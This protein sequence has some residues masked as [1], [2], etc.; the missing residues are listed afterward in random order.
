ML[1]MM[2]GYSFNRVE[3][4]DPNCPH[5]YY[6]ECKQCGGNDKDRKKGVRRQLALVKHAPD[7]TLVRHLP[8][9][10]AMANRDVT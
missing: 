4:L 5:R 7:C 9:L 10:Q 1:S 3:T 6:Y 8:R 2:I